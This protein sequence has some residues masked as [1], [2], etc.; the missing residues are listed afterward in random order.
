M[1]LIA[2][3]WLIVESFVVPHGFVKWFYLSF[4]IHPVFLVFCQLLL[5]LKEL[6]QLLICFFHPLKVVFRLSLF[7]FGLIVRVLL[8]LFSYIRPTKVDVFYDALVPDL[9]HISLEDCQIFVSCTKSTRSRSH[10]VEEIIQDSCVEDSWLNEYLYSDYYSSSALMYDVDMSES[11]LSNESEV[12]VLPDQ[13]KSSTSFPSSFMDQSDETG[14]S[15]IRPSTPSDPLIPSLNSNDSFVVDVEDPFHN[16][17]TSR[18]RFYNVLYHERLH[19][20]S[21]LHKHWLISNI[22]I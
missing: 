8:F 15:V 3:C 7:V 10:V 1:A 19:G 12:E 4:Y 20:I 22:F 14:D 21:K 9:K 16:E 5:W 11:M 2:S 13:H 6:M 18:V 17:Y